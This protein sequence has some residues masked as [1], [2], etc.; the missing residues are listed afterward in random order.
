MKSL[1]KFLLTTLIIIPTIPSVVWASQ[2][3][4]PGHRHGFSKKSEELNQILPWASEQKFGKVTVYSTI[5]PIPQQKLERANRAWDIWT[6]IFVVIKN[7]WWIGQ[8][9]RPFK[10]VVVSEAEF[11]NIWNRRAPG[12]TGLFL[13]PDEVWVK[14]MYWLRDFTVMHELL[15]KPLTWIYA[16]NFDAFRDPRFLGYSP[17]IISGAEYAVNKLTAE[18]G[19]NNQL[20]IDPVRFERLWQIAREIM[21]EQGFWGVERTPTPVIVDSGSGLPRGEFHEVLRW[22][23]EAYQARDRSGE[24]Y[25]AIIMFSAVLDWYNYHDDR[26]GIFDVA[27]CSA[28]KILDEQMG[29]LANEN[30]IVF[31]QNRQIS[32]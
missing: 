2:P 29:R 15:H 26:T 27:V 4:L 3:I 18:M 12:A 22:L 19:Q 23:Y 5:G 32:C 16:T 21:L 8:I 7:W 31:F 17:F 1:Y 9:P 6:H 14:G 20:T 24:V 10:L 30:P 28:K 11:E 13:Y 25:I